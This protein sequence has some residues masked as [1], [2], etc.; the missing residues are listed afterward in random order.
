MYC[1]HCEYCLHGCEGRTCPECGEA[2]NPDDPVTFLPERGDRLGLGPRVRWFLSAMFWAGWLYPPLWVASPYVAWLVAWLVLGY[3]PQP[4]LDDPKYIAPVVDVFY[5]LAML[6]MIVMPAA[7]MLGVT[8]IGL[9][10]V[11]KRRPLSTAALLGTLFIA[12]WAMAILFLRW[13][14]LRVGDWFMD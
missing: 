3:R 13:D 7:F 14:P 2:F 12:L 1:L 6:M 4:Y 8:A 9:H 10:I 5:W 11:Q